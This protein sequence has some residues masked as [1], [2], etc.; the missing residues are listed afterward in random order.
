MIDDT[1]GRIITVDVINA[2]RCLKKSRQLGVSFFLFLQEP[3]QPVTWRHGSLGTNA[4]GGMATWSFSDQVPGD[5]A[6]L[7]L[8]KTHHFTRHH[9][10]RLHSTRHHPARLHSARLHSARLH[11]ARLLNLEHLI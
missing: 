3:I 6:V 10:A 4:A 9:P 1:G 8:D 5:M 11:S 2:R 7:D